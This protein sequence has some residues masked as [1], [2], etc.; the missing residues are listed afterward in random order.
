MG[1]MLPF[2]IF[3]LRPEASHLKFIFSWSKEEDDIIS[4]NG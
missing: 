3:V 2:V 1:V 4:I